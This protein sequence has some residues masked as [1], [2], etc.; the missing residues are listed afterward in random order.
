MQLH[1][2]QILKR[3]A[4]LDGSWLV[5]SFAPLDKLSSWVAH[6]YQSF[7]LPSYQENYPEMAVDEV[8][9]FQRTTF[10]ADPDLQAYHAY[11][12]GRNTPEEVYSREVL[13]QYARWRKQGKLVKEPEEDPLQR[14]GNFVINRQGLITLSHTGRNQVERPTPEEILQA[15]L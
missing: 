7:I 14:G 2:P 4:E 6:F 11:G 13:R 9:I 8:E 15:M 1:Q 10:L 12:L 3:L 5:L